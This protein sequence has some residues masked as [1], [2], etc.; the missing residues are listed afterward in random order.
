[1]LEFRTAQGRTLHFEATPL[2]KG[3]EGSVYKQY[4][5]SGHGDVGDLAKI[6][7]FTVRGNR[8]DKEEKLKAMLSIK[9]PRPSYSYAWPKELL[10]DNY[11]EFCGYVMYLKYNKIEMGEVYGFNSRY[12]SERE[13]RFYV[14]AAMNLAQAVQ[15]A[16]DIG[17]VIGDLNDMNILIDAETAAITLIDNDSF[18]IEA[19]GKVH[20]CA[21]GKSEYIAPEIQNI[22]FSKEDLPTFTKETDN[23]SLAVLIFKLLMNGVH[24]F[25]SVGMDDNTIEDNIKAGL[26][27]FDP[28]ANA[29]KSPTAF[30][31]PSFKMLP[32]SLK[33]L[34][35][36]AFVTGAFI[37]KRRPSAQEF[38]DEFEAMV[39]ANAFYC[40]TSEPWH[41]YPNTRAECPWCEVDKKKQ[42][43]L[44]KITAL[45]NSGSLSAQATDYSVKR[46]PYAAPIQQEQPV[47]GEGN[48]AAGGSARSGGSP[49]IQQTPPIQPYEQPAAGGRASGGSP[50]RGSLPLK[51]VGII[52]AA[53]ALVIFGIVL[54]TN[55]GNSEL[56]SDPE[57]LCSDCSDCRKI[58]GVYGFGRVTDSGEKP[59]I[60][61]A[62][63]ILNHV[64]GLPSIIDGNP[65]ALAAA[66]ITAPLSNDPP[67]IADALA[68]L[69]FAVGLDSPLDEWY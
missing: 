49:P 65:D 7:D 24:P 68:I 66:K 32:D 44:D 37:P 53:V 60:Q 12:R 36:R 35:K 19:G 45:S 62:L 3:G 4:D 52:G 54:I 58:G 5:R 38:F 21:V 28:D 57:H 41:V 50:R 30:Y 22:N 31:A 61:D 17:Q 34:F 39:T 14:S 42:E 48:T 26:F 67:E 40:C 33:G 69:T 55:G 25:N 2:G 23:F 51:L 29:G 1:M 20:R 6:F 64:V 63:E 10:Y 15:G 11:G 18:H 43:Q 8:A 56:P 47:H 27:P 13:W 46:Q 16:H 9:S 59:G